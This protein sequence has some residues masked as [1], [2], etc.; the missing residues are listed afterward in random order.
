MHILHPIFLIQEAILIAM[1]RLLGTLLLTWCQAKCDLTAVFPLCGRPQFSS[2]ASL[3]GFSGEKPFP[4]APD[5][6]QSMINKASSAMFMINVRSIRSIS[7]KSMSFATCQK[8]DIPARPLKGRD[9]KNIS[10]S[11]KNISLHWFSSL[12]KAS[13]LIQEFPNQASSFIWV[14]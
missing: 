5:E 2:P 6:H 3:T 4:T 1:F 12:V 7:I 11:Q 10:K 9:T 8:F 13:P 14:N